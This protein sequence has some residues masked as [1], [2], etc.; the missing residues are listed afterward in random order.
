MTYE[1][2]PANGYRY[3]NLDRDAAYCLVAGYDANARMRIIKRWQELEAGRTPTTYL[4]ALKALVAAEEAKEAAIKALEAE[5]PYAEIGHLVTSKEVITRRDWLAL[6][7]TD[8]GVK[9]SEH[10]LTQFL[11]DRGYI[12]YDQLDHRARAYAKY[13]RFF[14]LV[15]ENINGIT[16]PILKVTGAGVRELTPIVIKYF[17]A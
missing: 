16:L 8:W 1:G 17:S 4:G 11:V 9:I 13:S 14:K 3:F 6:M 15:L 12:Y 2:D 7:K 5:A 10:A